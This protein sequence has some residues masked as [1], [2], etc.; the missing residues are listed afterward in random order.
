M[1]VAAVFGLGDQGRHTTTEAVSLINLVSSLLLWRLVLL[2]ELVVVSCCCRGH[3]SDGDDG[4][5]TSAFPQT[6]PVPK[7]APLINLNTSRPTPTTTR[8]LFPTA[9]SLGI[10]GG[11]AVTS[12][13]LALI[14][15]YVDNGIT[16]K[17]EDGEEV[18]PVTAKQIG[19]SDEVSLIGAARG[20][21]GGIVL[22]CLF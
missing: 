8:P 11:A 3:V 19:N 9:G 14:D 22:V 4:D 1:V 13:V 18:Y 10:E 5:M 6:S 21:G 7:Q 2:S 15:F 16:E 20:G 17:G 12:D